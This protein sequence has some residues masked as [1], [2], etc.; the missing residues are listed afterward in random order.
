MS[1]SR[2]WVRSHGSEWVVARAG[3]NNVRLAP[4]LSLPLSPLLPL[5]Q[6]LF[7]MAIPLLLHSVL[8]QHK[9]H[10]RSCQQQPPNLEHSSL[11]NCELFHIF[12]N[13]SVLGI[14]LQQ[15]KNRSIHL[16]KVSKSN[17][18]SN[19]LGQNTS[20][21]SFLFFSVWAPLIPIQLAP[22]HTP[23]IREC[24]ISYSHLAQN[25][26]SEQRQGL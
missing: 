4:C 7:C 1:F 12:M 15:E 24:V 17:P 18:S 8:R 19:W 6:A 20:E 21:C 5:T 14:L 11:Q 9:V 10:I 2:D 13:Y 25:I 22:A 23:K 26:R 3:C 16:P